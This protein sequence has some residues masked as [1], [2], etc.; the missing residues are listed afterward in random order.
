M[1]N[2]TIVNR[3]IS[4]KKNQLCHAMLTCL[5]TS[6]AVVGHAENP[7]YPVGSPV[8]NLWAN[9]YQIEKTDPQQAAKIL[10]QLAALTP[11]DLNLWK[12]ST[13]LQIRLK[14][15][16]QALASL[17]RALVLNPNDEQLLLQKA[18]LLNAAQR[19]KEALPI[20]QQLS[21]SQDPATAAKAQ[22]AVKNLSPAENSAPDS[23][24]FGDIYFSPSYEGRYDDV[25]FPLKVRYGRNFGEN[26]RVQIYSFL[27]INRDTQSKGGARPEIIDQNALIV[28]LGANY[29]PW[30]NLPIR[31]YLE[32]GG[33]Y[34]LVDLNR[35]KF[36]ESVNGGI[37]AY[38]EWYGNQFKHEAP[39]NQAVWF[40]EAYGN[41]ASYSREDYNVISDLR[42]RSGLN[43]KHEQ[44]GTWQAY[45]KA[46][47]MNDTNHEYYNNIFEIGPGLAW[48]PFHLPIKLRVE[49]MYGKYVIGTPPSVKSTFNNTR[50][51]LTLFKDF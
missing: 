41:I 45:L 1:A 50:V 29:Q 6:F 32:A 8:Y 38:Q 25:I 16:D 37:T 46:H 40:N 5:I 4:I 22:V 27:N 14:H 48:Q 20:F 28:G 49:Q 39:S 10:E 23:P 3:L 43:Y 51:E 15:N 26:N 11:N 18:Y 31:I 17:D 36:R 13:Y 34:D 30:L 7:T 35:K 12:T 44:L 33:S 2:L 21:H 19:S 9:Y 24:Y 42:W 47:T